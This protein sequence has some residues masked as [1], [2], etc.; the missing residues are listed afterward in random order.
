MELLCEQTVRL[1]FYEVNQI[2]VD[3]VTYAYAW[4]KEAPLEG[5]LRLAQIED[6]AAMKLEDVT[7]RGSKKDFIDV[8][9]LLDLFSLKEMLNWYQR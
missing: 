1:Q 5:G 7:N 9:V 8:A 4:L 6:I 3:F 2:K